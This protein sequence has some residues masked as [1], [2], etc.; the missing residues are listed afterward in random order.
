MDTPHWSSHLDQIL[1]LVG[2]P[3]P[4]FCG[5]G[6]NLPA[7]DDDDDEYVEVVAVVDD[8]DYKDE[9]DDA[10][11]PPKRRKMATPTKALSTRA[12][13]SVLFGPRWR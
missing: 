4:G 10:P 8:D 7:M 6:D 9:E 12:R 2:K 1:E 5:M 3:P 13:T 11:P